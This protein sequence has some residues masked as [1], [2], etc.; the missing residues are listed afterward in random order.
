MCGIVVANKTP[1]IVEWIPEPCVKYHKK[2]P[3]KTQI[4]AGAVVRDTYRA[5]K[6]KN[7]FY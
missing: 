2:S 3:T 4:R 1:E 5:A 6:E 7:K